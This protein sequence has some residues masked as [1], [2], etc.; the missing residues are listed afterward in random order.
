M[1]GPIL[2]ILLHTKYIVSG[3]VTSSKKSALISRDKNAEAN[4]VGCVPRVYFYSAHNGRGA[5]CMPT[6][7]G[8]EPEP[9][10]VLR[11]NNVNHYTMCFP[12]ID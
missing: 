3:L 11:F 6:G 7:L 5:R 2:G 1:G 8:F 4:E 10:Q 9:S 12:P